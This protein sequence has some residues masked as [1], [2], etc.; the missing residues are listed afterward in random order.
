MIFYHIIPS[1]SRQKLSKM[2][3]I[4]DT[5]RFFEERSILTLVKPKKRRPHPNEDGVLVFLTDIIHVIVEH[6][7]NHRT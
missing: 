4:F 2:A 1:L 3:I 5:V 7:R 6:L